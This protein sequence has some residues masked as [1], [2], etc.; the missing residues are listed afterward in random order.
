MNRNTKI[1]LLIGAF[2]LVVVILVPL[3]WGANSDWHMGQR[4]MSGFGWWWFMPLF[5]I[6]F[7]ILIIWAIVAVIR[8]S[9][10]GGH[11][12]SPEHHESA[13]DVLKKRYARGEISKEEFEEKKKDLQG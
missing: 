10:S 12:T 5:G 11:P 6:F 13:L 7:W 3:I 2:V 9:V 8:G 1:A 4:H